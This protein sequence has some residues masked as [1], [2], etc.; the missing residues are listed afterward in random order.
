MHALMNACTAVFPY[1]I[2]FL[3]SEKTHMHKHT[4]TV[5]VFLQVS[6]LGPSINI[7]VIVAN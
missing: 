7:I 4:H 2:K 1:V 6:L 3:A 5:L